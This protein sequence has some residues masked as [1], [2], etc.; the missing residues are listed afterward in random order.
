MTIFSFVSHTIF[1]IVNL[2]GKVVMTASAQLMCMG[3]FQVAKATYAGVGLIIAY[4]MLKPKS[5]K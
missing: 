5:K 1:I 3:L 4:V 2:N